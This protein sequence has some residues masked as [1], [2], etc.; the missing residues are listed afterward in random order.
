MEITKRLGPELQELVQS[1]PRLAW[2][3]D[4]RASGGRKEDNVTWWQYGGGSQ[5][6]KEDGG[7]CWSGGRV[8]T[9]D[10]KH[11]NVGGDRINEQEG[12]T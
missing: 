4:F 7:S 8:Q 11:L 5:G 2:S 9:D 6:E 3:L 12:L 10:D 1:L